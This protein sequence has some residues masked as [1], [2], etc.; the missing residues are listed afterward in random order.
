MKRTETVTTVQ[1]FLGLL[2]LEWSGGKVAALKLPAKPPRFVMVRLPRG[3]KPDWRRLLD[4]EKADLDLS[5]HSRFQRSVWAQARKIPF[6][7]V[8][9]YGW[10]ARKIGK[11]GASR[12]VGRALKENPWP[13]IIPCHRV[14]RADGSLG[15]F[16]SGLK[17]KKLLIDI[18]KELSCNLTRIIHNPG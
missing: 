7:E 9:S 1:S 6:G 11:P 2:K 14:V 13:L 15:G 12:A 16:N 5:A 10:V 17:W 18:E 4:L 3:G 8:R